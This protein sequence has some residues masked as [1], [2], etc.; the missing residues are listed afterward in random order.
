VSTHHNS[1]FLGKPVS[2]RFEGMV[3]PFVS[4]F[5]IS[6]KGVPSFLSQ[7]PRS[8]SRCCCHPCC[9]HRRHPHPFRWDQVPRFQ[10]RTSALR[11]QWDCPGHRASPGCGPGPG[12]GLGTRPGCDPRCDPGCRPVTRPSCGP[13]TSLCASREDSCDSCGAACSPPFSAV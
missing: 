1:L 8:R 13:S 4:R 9:C 6:L 3:F 11:S 5:W 2:L 12:Y 7:G 10:I